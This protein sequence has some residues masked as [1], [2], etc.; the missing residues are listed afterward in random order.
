M[1][2][3]VKTIPEGGVVEKISKT[4]NRPY[5]LTTFIGEDDT[6][7]QEVYGKYEVGQEIEGEWKDTKWGKKFEIARPEG[8]GG[9]NRGGYRGKTPEE[10]ESIERQSSLS[11]AATVVGNFYKG[12]D[13]FASY[14]EGEKITLEKYAKDVSRTG[15]Y[16]YDNLGTKAKSTPAASGGADKLQSPS[17]QAKAAFNDESSTEPQEEEVTST[18]FGDL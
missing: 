1:K 12:A 9:A 16:L 17:D 8:S 10:M 5:H 2:V 3:K 6:L 18:E 4:T 15:K 14:P 13:S 11:V 7:Y